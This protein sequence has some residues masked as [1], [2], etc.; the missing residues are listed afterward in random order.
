MRKRVMTMTMMMTMRRRNRS[1]EAGTEKCLMTMVTM[2][3]RSGSPE[4]GTEFCLWN[5]RQYYGKSRQY[6]LANE[7]IRNFYSTDVVRT[8]CYCS[9]EVGNVSHNRVDY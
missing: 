4:A 3:R 6:Y 2:R 8:C 9:R 7:H 5:I 1:P